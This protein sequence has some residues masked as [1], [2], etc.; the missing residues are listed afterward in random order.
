MT[1]LPWKVFSARTMCR[2]H[3]RR[4]WTHHTN[5]LR[6]SRQ[7]GRTCT[8]A[9]AAVHGPLGEEV[10][11]LAAQERGEGCRQNLRQLEGGGPRHSHQA[12]PHL[13]QLR[14]HLCANDPESV[15]A[16]ASACR[17]PPVLR[18]N[19]GQRWAKEKMQNA[20]HTGLSDCLGIALNTSAESAPEATDTSWRWVSTRKSSTVARS[21]ASVRSAPTRMQPTSWRSTCATATLI[22]EWRIRVLVLCGRAGVAA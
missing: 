4:R 14:R 3:P 1:D 8:G 16:A 15:R 11:Q 5:H 10:E 20:D 2:A 19:N 6:S 13:L 12:E 9:G 17:K 22:S 18:T 7:H 21:G